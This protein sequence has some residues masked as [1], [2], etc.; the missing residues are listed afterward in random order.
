M[1]IREEVLTLIKVLG[2]LCKFINQRIIKHLRIIFRPDSTAKLSR[3]NTKILTDEVDGIGSELQGENRFRFLKLRFIR[4][5]FEMLQSR[6]FQAIGRDLVTD[7]V[8]HFNQ[9][10]E[11]LVGVGLHF[12]LAELFVLE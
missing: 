4:E 2:L 9:R 10:E 5:L 6:A 1:V 11:I 8:Q 7:L 3:L 12:L